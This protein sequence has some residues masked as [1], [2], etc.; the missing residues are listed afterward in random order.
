MDVPVLL[1]SPAYLLIQEDG[2]FKEQKHPNL[3]FKALT[4][5]VRAIEDIARRV[6][7]T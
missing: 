5:A 1:I 6:S 7:K 3:I 4:D 2:T